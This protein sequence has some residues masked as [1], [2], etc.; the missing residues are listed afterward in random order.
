MELEALLIQTE[1]L[2]LAQIDLKEFRAGKVSVWVKFV[3]IERVDGTLMEQTVGPVHKL[4]FLAG[5]YR[6][7]IHQVAQNVVLAV[8]GA[9]VPTVK[10]IPNLILRLFTHKVRV[11]MPG[12][13]PLEEPGQLFAKVTVYEYAPDLWEQMFGKKQQRQES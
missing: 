6:E 1:Q 2:I 7:L 12:A 8:Y 4:I 5:S 11:A 10:E 13:P 9:E 3:R